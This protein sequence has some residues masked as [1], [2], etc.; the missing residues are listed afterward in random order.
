[1]ESKDLP[2]IRKAIT[3]AANTLRDHGKSV[4]YLELYRWD[5]PGWDKKLINNRNAGL[6]INPG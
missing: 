3:D 4:V 1:M 5:P 6:S 2:D